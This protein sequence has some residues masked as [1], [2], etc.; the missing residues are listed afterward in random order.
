MTL[1]FYVKVNFK[2]T[3]QIHICLNNHISQNTVDTD[4][5]KNLINHMELNATKTFKVNDQGH[6]AQG[7]STNLTCKSSLNKRKLNYC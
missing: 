3:V 5:Y 4:R 1:T 7:H 2:I 6:S